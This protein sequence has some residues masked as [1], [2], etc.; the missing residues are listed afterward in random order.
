MRSVRRVFLSH[1]SEFAAHPKSKSYVDAAKDACNSNECLVED[2]SGWSAADFRPAEVCRRRVRGCDVYVGIIGFSYGSP[3]LDEPDHS[4]TELE[5][6]EARSRGLHV[7]V[8][9]LADEGDMQIGLGRG[10]PKHA[11]RQEAFRQRLR[12]EHVTIREFHNPD[13]LHNLIGQ[14]LR[15]L[16]DS[17]APTPAGREPRRPFMARKRPASA[18]DRPALGEICSLVRNIVDHLDT[19]PPGRVRP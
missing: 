2:M 17:D 4:Y 11:D 18:V 1:T 14:S 8:F 6:E 3:V 15:E 19:R 16:S 5:F 13:E 9:L 7:L 12:G 10:N